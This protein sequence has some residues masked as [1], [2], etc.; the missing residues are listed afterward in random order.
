[1][2]PLEEQSLSWKPRRPSAKLEQRLFGAAADP[3]DLRAMWRA[4]V[5]AAACLVL[6]VAMLHAPGGGTG[7]S[8]AQEALLLSSLS[9]QQYAAYLPGSFACTANRLDTFGW[10]NGGAF[11]SSTLSTS[12][13]NA[14]H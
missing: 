3:R 12:P 14:K 9:N 8:P 10:T 1:M 4:L 2:K 5:P 6:T 13:G 7:A 11:P